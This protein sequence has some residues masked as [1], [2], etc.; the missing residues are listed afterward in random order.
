MS[1]EV[2]IRSN[3]KEMGQRRIKRTRG[4]EGEE[5]EEE[6]GRDSDQMR[7]ISGR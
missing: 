1:V 5:E 6:E 2:Q 4:E 3:E 7:V